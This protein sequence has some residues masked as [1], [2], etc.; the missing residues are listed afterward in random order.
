MNTR[1][2]ELKITTP[3]DTFHNPKIPVQVSIFHGGN[4]HHIQLSY[5][6]ATELSDKLWALRKG[7]VA[8]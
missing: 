8:A 2:I 4:A 5:A 1:K 3:A 7:A 6:E